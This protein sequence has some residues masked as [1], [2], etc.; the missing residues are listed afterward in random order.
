LGDFRNDP[1][2]MLLRLKGRGFLPETNLEIIQFKSNLFNPSLEPKP[3]S[4]FYIRC[5]IRVSHF[6]RPLGFHLQNVLEDSMNDHG[7]CAEIFFVVNYH[8]FVKN[9]LEIIILLQFPFFYLPL[10]DGVLRIFC[11]NI[12][13]IIKFG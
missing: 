11:F 7:F 5:T 8:H 12:L 9:I 4:K 3:T 2:I 6:E 13:N 1:K 10:N